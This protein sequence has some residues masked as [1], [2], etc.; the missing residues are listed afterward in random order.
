MGRGRSVQTWALQ[1]RKEKFRMKETKTMGIM[2]DLQY[3]AEGA[4]GAGEGGAAAGG[5]GQNAETGVNEGTDA[6]PRTRRAKRNPLADVK[7]GIQP[8]ESAAGQGD[9]GR[10]AAGKDGTPGGEGAPEESFESLIK[11]KYKQEYDARMQKALNG[12]FAEA[13]KIEGRMGKMAPIIQEMAARYGV[14]GSDMETL[15]LDAL[16]AKVTQD[17]R[18]YEEE[19]AREGVPVDLLMQRKSVERQQAAL[20]QQQRRIREAN[21]AQAEVSE[22]VQQAV[23]LKATIPEFDLD[24][25]MENPAFARL[26][27]KPPR[28]AG[29]PLESAYYAIHH[30]EIEEARRRQQYQ[31]TQEAVKQTAQKVSNAVASGSRRPAENGAGAAAAAV[32]RSDPQTLT[33]AERAEIRR[34]VSRG[35][36]IVF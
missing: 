3:F 14:D 20:D 7:F 8:N 36:Q 22:L 17:R 19:A 5:A 12:R 23:A 6:A 34:R 9:A 24:A 29:V 31:A 11:G 13:R 15:D 2:F 35:E 25:E 1:R 30:Q 26:A 28:G 10:D 27:L 32:T 21:A 18:M 16:Y 4:G 33:K